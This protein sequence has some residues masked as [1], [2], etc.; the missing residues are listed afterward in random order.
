MTIESLFW[1]VVIM[2]IVAGTIWLYD[3]VMGND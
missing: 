2:S 3:K 1:Y